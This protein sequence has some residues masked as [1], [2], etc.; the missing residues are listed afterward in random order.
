MHKK[1]QIYLHLLQPQ[2]QEKKK[3][4]TT[5][6]NKNPQQKS[7]MFPTLPL[8][9]LWKETSFHLFHPPTLHKQKASSMLKSEKTV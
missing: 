1:N 3:E 7:G 5:F 4:K 2:K 8:T 6:R 9:Q